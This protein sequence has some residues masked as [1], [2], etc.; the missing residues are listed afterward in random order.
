[1]ENDAVLGPGE[2]EL[3]GLFFF[4]APPSGM[5]TLI[6]STRGVHNYSRQVYYTAQHHTLSKQTPHIYICLFFIHPVISL[7]KD[8]VIRRVGG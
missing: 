2:D 7:L 8:S 3:N 6:A 1:M 5:T 4:K